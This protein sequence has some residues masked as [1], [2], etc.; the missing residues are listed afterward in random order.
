MPQPPLSTLH[1]S[2][3]RHVVDHG[4]APDLQALSATLG[5]TEIETAAGLDALQAE[6][7]VVLHPNSNRIWVVHPFSLAPTTFWVRAGEKSWWGNCAWC[8][9]GVA[10]LVGG[11]VTITTT[12]GAHDRQVELHIRDGRVVEEYLF[13]HFPVP[14]R[15]AW[16]NVLYTCSTMLLFDSEAAV[17]AWCDQHAVARGDV[18]P[19]RRVW[20]LA[21][22]WYGRHLDPYWR[23]W[24]AAEAKEIFERFGL[25][26]E[27]WD[28]DES[29]ARF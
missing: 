5:C 26:G 29:Q 12:L 25:S 20:E 15:R 11:D 23:K 3:V 2:I 24:T 8:S 27:I 9:L 13:V 19:V 17:D 22:V 10:A 18:R 14:M 1:Y 16:D 28:L 7:G 4:F 21:Q 6:H